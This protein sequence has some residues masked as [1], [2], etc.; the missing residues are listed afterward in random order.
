[1][2][3]RGLHDAQRR[4]VIRGE[5]RRGWLRQVEQLQRRGIRT[6]FVEVTF[7]DQVRVDGQAALG[8]RGAVAVQSVACATQL[9]RTGDVADAP[10]TEVEQVARRI[11][12]T[13]TIRSTD[14]RADIADALVVDQDIRKM[15]LAKGVDVRAEVLW[16]QEQNALGEPLG[17]GGDVR[18]F[19]GH[20][21]ARRVQHEV[22]AGRG[23]F[24]VDAT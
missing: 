22:I 19:V 8:Q 11:V 18:R 4:D 3:A 1:M 24:F 10:V 13:L 17:E 21:I 20:A 2:V 6:R 14:G 23:Q 15:L 9:Q 16:Q 5:D 12:T 7:A